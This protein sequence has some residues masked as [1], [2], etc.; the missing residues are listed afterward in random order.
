MTINARDMMQRRVHTVPPE[1]TLPDLEEHFARHR[2]SGFPVVDGG[3]LVGVVS[4]S[5]IVQRLF[6][7]H[8]TA[9]TTSDFY[10]DASGFHEVPLKTFEAIASRI[11]QSIESLCVKDVMA[12][13]PIKVS[14]DRPVV[15]VAQLLLEKRIHRVPVVEQEVLVGIISTLDL[16]RLIVDG[17]LKP[18]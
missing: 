10:Q 12:P 9:S 16:A 4:R 6:I 13:D 18:P 8:Y 7:E 17:Q 5:D 14:L 15:E 1:M 3:Q 2:V 11:G